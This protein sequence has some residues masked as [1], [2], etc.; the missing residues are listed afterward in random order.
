MYF[1]GF[2]FLLFSLSSFNFLIFLFVCSIS[3]FILFN[4]GFIIEIF[5]FTNS[6]DISFL[7]ASISFFNNVVGSANGTEYFVEKL[8]NNDQGNMY[9]QQIEIP[10]TI[11]QN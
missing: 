10:I 6:W 9:I 2:N 8:T 5:K 1:S 3:N 7:R 11:K 4:W